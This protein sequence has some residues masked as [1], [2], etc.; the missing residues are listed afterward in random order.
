MT[1]EKATRHMRE[2]GFFRSIP[3]PP[4]CCFIMRS[5]FLLSVVCR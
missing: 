5:H 4:V 1:I 2:T 3:P